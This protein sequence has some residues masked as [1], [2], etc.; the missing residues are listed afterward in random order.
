V[1]KSAGCHKNP[2]YLTGTTCPLASITPQ[3][4]S[5]R[6]NRTADSMNDRTAAWY[7]SVARVLSDP[8]FAAWNGHDCTAA[9]K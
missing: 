4:R 8:A 7:N 9:E 6:P 5:N 3:L 1:Q 2:L